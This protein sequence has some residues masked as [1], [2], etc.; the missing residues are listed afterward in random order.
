MTDLM[1]PKNYSRI[2]VGLQLPDLIQV[3]LDSFNRLKD[4]GLGELFN[5]ISPIVSYQNE[6]RLHFPSDTP[7]SREFGLRYW[8]EAPKN[9]IEECLERDLTYACPLYVSVL[10]EGSDLAEKV[11]QD[12]F[13]GDFPEMTEKGT[14]IINGT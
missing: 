7:L 12:I 1:P 5:E 9:S 10:L 13:L 14:F 6:L 11:K 4:Y 2:P 8:F 3:Q